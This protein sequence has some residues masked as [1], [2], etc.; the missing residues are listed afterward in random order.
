[1]ELSHQHKDKPMISSKDLS[2]ALYALSKAKGYAATV[3]LTLGLTLGTL[4]AMFNLN[5]QII[6]APLPYPQEERLIAAT[7]AWLKPDGSINR[8][9]AT[10]KVITQIYQQ[11]SDKLS[12]QALYGG[13]GFATLRDLPNAPSISLVY[14]TPGYMRMYQMPLL[15]GRAFS[16]EEDIGSQ[17]AVA[18]ISERLWR[19][20]YNADPAFV[21]KKIQIGQT[22]FTVVGI[23]AGDFAEPKL[24]GPDTTHDLWLPWDFNEG[25]Y[26][27]TPGGLTRNLY[28]LSQLKNTNDREAFELEVRPQLDDFF[29]Q[30]RSTANQGGLP[31]SV[32]F[33][34][35][36]LRQVLEGDSRQATLWMLAGSLVLLL[37]AS[38]NITNLILS[39][40]ARQQRTMTIQ[41]AL[42]AQRHHLLAT[43]WSEL[44]VL[45]AAALLLAFAIAE[46]AYL[47]LRWYAAT[48]LPRLQEL[49]L[50]SPTLLFAIA[51]SLLL[52]LG[53]AQLISRQ[54][55]Y[56]ALQQNL[57]SSGKGSGVQIS[58]RIRQLLISTQVMLA[59][60]LL[61]CA[62]QVLSQSLAQL[63]QQIGF[64]TADR[65]QVLLED[66]AAS[67]VNLSAEQRA[68]QERQRGTE[69]LQIRELLLQH[70]A[71]AD[72]SLST[73]AP[74]GYNGVSAGF[75]AYLREAQ[76][77]QTRLETRETRTDQHYLPMF[78]MQLLQGRNFTAQEVAN[79]TP[80]LII[81]QALAEQLRPDGKVLGQRL[82][83]SGSS[84][85]F[86][87]IGVTTNRYLPAGSGVD[88]LPYRSYSPKAADNLLLQLKPGKKIDKT[89]LNAL[90]QQVSPQLRTLD[91]YSIEENANQV[92]L[93]SSLAA[94]V[95]SAL[96]ALSFLLAA[97]G[98]YG[99]LSYSVQMRRFELG[100]RMA[101]GA[102]P[103]T[104]LQQLLGENLKPVLMGLALAVLALAAL[105]LGLKQSTF[106]VQ[107]SVGGFALPLGLIVLL[108]VLTSFLS[109]WGIIR[110]PAIYA[111]R[112]Q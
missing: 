69:L 24:F 111:L 11:P 99:V 86:E 23:A 61:V 98:I 18:V 94:A 90:L 27:L 73:N 20:H 25:F 106:N 57:Q 84:Q 14:T 82:Y 35:T 49:G 50:D 3:V 60:L 48:T 2:N 100:V 26:Q 105:W 67:P 112:G 8:P 43:V 38:A 88:E 1:M 53:F 110:K 70:P 59:A 33:H 93:R 10:P 37:I 5:Y 104:I 63:R 46:L 109:V 15:H 44:C 55:N 103:L 28:Y 52:T 62:C 30:A 56:R 34:A 12:D 76:Q 68:A 42:G 96:V 40:A 81:N 85:A 78:D 87:I 97:I 107:L 79:Q 75:A 108:T 21:G 29:A 47:L 65:Y 6:L 51:V 101:I 22:A 39:R 80:V 16:S 17:Q 9:V 102:R 71:I 4:V 54:L 13:S 32:R 19:S 89:T 77:Q 7:S 95:T 31:F 72:A 83:S 91:I 92:L 74:V 58:S 41:A 66:I 36:P 64:A 45:M